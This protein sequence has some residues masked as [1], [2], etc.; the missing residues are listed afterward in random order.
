MTISA[1][2]RLKG[3]IEEVVLGTVMAHVVVCVGD[4]LIE[5]AITRRK[6]RRATAQERRRGDRNHKVYR[7][8]DAEGLR[9]LSTRSLHH[10]PTVRDVCRWE[11]QS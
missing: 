4:N 8:N 9:A 3:T 1:R 2:N 7:G 6:C 11:R 10:A 5:S